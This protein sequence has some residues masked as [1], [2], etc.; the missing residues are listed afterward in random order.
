MNNMIYDFDK[1]DHLEIIMDF[2][3]GADDVDSTTKEN[4]WGGKWHCFRG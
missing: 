1:E 3:F 2:L 4:L